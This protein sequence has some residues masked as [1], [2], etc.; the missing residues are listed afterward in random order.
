MQKLPQE[1]E[2]MLRD[3]IAHYGNELHGSYEGVNPRSYTPAEAQDE[4]INYIAQNFVPVESLLPVW[5]KAR[6]AYNGGEQVYDE[7][8][9]DMFLFWKQT[10]NL[11]GQDM[12]S[13]E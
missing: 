2:R 1:L 4:I 11:I 12:T 9:H 10:G 8:Y 3:M 6:N 13:F 7:W 5:E